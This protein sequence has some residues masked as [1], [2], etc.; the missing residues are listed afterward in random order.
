M[1]WEIWLDEG[2]PACRINTQE[3]VRA[4]SL[5]K[6]RHANN[7]PDIEKLLLLL[8]LVANLCIHQPSLGSEWWRVHL[9]L[10]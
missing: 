1:L 8:L 2:D 3:E 9:S 4:K 7:N 6:N 5:K 10:D